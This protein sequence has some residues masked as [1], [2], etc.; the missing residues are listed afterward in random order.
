[1]VKTLRDTYG[2]FYQQNFFIIKGNKH[3]LTKVFYTNPKGR[4][5]GGLEYKNYS[6]AHR[7]IVNSAVHFLSPVI[8]IVKPKEQNK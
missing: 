2:E 8:F 1:M 3:N 4:I 5:L 7:V 6:D